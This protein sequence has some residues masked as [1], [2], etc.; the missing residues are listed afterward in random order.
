M[1]ENRDKIFVNN[2]VLGD[3]DKVIAYIE[4]VENVSRQ[5]FLSGF[6]AAC[7]QSRLH[8]VKYM[9][10][11]YNEVRPYVYYGIYDFLDGLLNFVFDNSDYNTIKF[12]VEE[13]ALTSPSDHRLHN[14][15]NKQLTKIMKKI[16]NKDHVCKLKYEYG[17]RLL[18]CNGANNYRRLR[19]TSNFRLYSLYCK[20]SRV[21]PLTDSKYLEL[22]RQHPIY[23]LLVNYYSVKGG[24]G[25]VREAKNWAKILPIDVIREMFTY[26]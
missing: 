13:L 10:S 12:I 18:L 4:N 22:L 23:V 17:V 24:K 2:C 19:L 16:E 25:G 1:N 15:L 8:I 7:I 11:K 20:H 26:L 14:S 9:L 21:K 6:Y 3:L 5:G